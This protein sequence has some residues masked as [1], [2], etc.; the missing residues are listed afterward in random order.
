MIPKYYTR[1]LFNEINKENIIMIAFS[2]C[3]FRVNMNYHIC[4]IFQMIEQLISKAW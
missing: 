1:T 3:V 2:R 4:K